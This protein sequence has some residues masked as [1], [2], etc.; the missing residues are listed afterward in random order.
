VRTALTIKVLRIN[1]VQRLSRSGSTELAEVVTL[2]MRDLS[3]NK[4]HAVSKTGH[5]CTV[6]RMMLMSL[7]SI[8]AAGKVA[9]RLLEE[10]QHVT[11]QRG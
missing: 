4:I 11:P 3:R 5:W 6:S 2:P 7:R 1:W 10:T 8:S 9:T